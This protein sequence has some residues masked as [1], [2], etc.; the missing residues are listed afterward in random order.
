MAT[1]KSFTPVVFGGTFDP[2]HAGH[3]SGIRYLL[4]RHDLVVIA[5]T[6]K[7]PWKTAAPTPFELRLQMMRLVLQAES[8][9]FSESPQTTSGLF[10]F[11]ERYTF[12]ED[13]V[14]AFR[15]VHPGALA[16]AV[17][18]DEAEAVTRWKHWASLD[19]GLVI[20]PI[21]VLSHSTG[22]RQGILPPHPAIVE[23]VNAHRL[24]EKS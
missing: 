13:F 19:V 14:R 4:T 22:V 21:E 17:G 9:V 12:A 10:L 5:P 3:V 11:T 1:R 23:F 7:N 16:W 6:E 15:A 2:I 24:Y 18:E 20:V 8:L